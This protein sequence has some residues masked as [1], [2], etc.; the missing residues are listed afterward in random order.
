MRRRDNALYIFLSIFSVFLLINKYMKY[1]IVI[2]FLMLGLNMVQRNAF[3]IKKNGLL[4]VFVLVGV[5]VCINCASSIVLNYSAYFSISVAIKEVCR[6]IVYATILEIL[7]LTEIDV[8]I[9]KQVWKTILMVVVAIAVLQYI[10]IF[11]IDIVLKS[12]YGDSVQFLNTQYSDLSSFRCGSIFVNPNVFACF[13]VAFLGNYFCVMSNGRETIVSK[14]VTLVLCIIGLVL[15]GSRTGLVLG[16]VLVI[17]YTVLIAEYNLRYILKNLIII[18][19]L[20]CGVLLILKLFFDVDMSTL[21]TFRM[22]QV[23]GGMDDSFGIKIGI[24]TNLLKGGS[25]LNC[26]IGYGPFDYASSIDL[27]VDFDFGYFTT[28]FGCLG[29]FLYVGLLG[30]ILKFNVKQ[31]ASRKLRNIMF[32]VITVIFGITAGVYFNMRIFAIYM[33]MF[34]PNFKLN[35]NSFDAVRM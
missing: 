11:D 21:A 5:C 32:F 31:D 16:L 6:C 12:I 10:K 35:K 1:G 29:L 22:F 2:L 34:L 30:A 9:Y 8:N 25:A 13:L 27:L 19:G 15:S 4:T 7:L 3:T 18:G 17:V 14:V 33:A 28:F 26:L 23:K 20:I 24:Y